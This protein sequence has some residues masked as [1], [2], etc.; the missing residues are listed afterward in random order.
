[1]TKKQILDYVAKTPYNTNIAV[2]SGMLDTFAAGDNKE[3]T[4]LT[5]TA[6]D[7]YTPDEGKVYKK[8]TVD[9]PQTELIELTITDTSVTEYTAPEGKAYSKVTIE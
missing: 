5:A 1:M 6:N 8:V 7:V 3:E 9:V 2:L 4:E